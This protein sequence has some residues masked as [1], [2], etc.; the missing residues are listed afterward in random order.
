MVASKQGAG[1]HGP[2]P[3]VPGFPILTPRAT[4]PK[5]GGLQEA[6]RGGG[7]GRGCGGGSPPG[8]GA[9]GRPQLSMS[10][11]IRGQCGNTEQ[12]ALC[13]GASRLRAADA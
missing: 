3:I 13:F 2:L 10:V 7:E 8:S 12:P 4:S 11:C 9:P 5:E 6:G 1:Q